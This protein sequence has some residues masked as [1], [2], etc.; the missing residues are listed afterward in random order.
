M[1]NRL[2]TADKLSEDSFEATIR[3]RTID[4]YIGQKYIK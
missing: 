1:E 2:V 3:P 4:E